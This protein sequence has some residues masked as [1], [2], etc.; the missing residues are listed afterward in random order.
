MLSEDDRRR[1]REEE[2]YRL[3]IREEHAEKE[4]IQNAPSYWSAFWLNFFLVGFGF[5][6]IGEWVTALVYII[7]AITLG[8]F[9]WPLVGVLWLIS[10][11]H[12]MSAYN[13]K[14]S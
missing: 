1:I 7:L 13:R 3:L 5:F 11:F 14:Y 6:V 8:S 10:M 2:E 9:F 12:V 4:R